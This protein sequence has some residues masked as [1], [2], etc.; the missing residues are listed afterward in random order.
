MCN[1]DADKR[2]T[3]AI[4]KSGGHAL[5]VN[6][7]AKEIPSARRP[8]RQTASVTLHPLLFSSLQLPAYLARVFV[9]PFLQGLLFEKAAAYVQI[10][11]SPKGI[12]NISPNSGGQWLLYRGKKEE[13]ADGVT[14]ICLP[15]CM[16]MYICTYT[17]NRSC[18]FNT[19]TYTYPCTQTHIQTV[20]FEKHLRES[21]CMYS[22][23]FYMYYS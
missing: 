1:M 6:G 11:L 16:Y 20:S 14:A 23:Y 4:R 12:C 5:P 15:A 2:Q 3:C 21:G 17:C 10:N 18:I 9:F 13:V 22:I 19:Y 7:A 8:G